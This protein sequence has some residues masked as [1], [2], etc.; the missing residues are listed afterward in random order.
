[1]VFSPF[2]V[3]EKLLE[4]LE[5]DNVDVEGF[6]FF[7]FKWCEVIV[8]L[9]ATNSKYRFKDTFFFLSYF[10]TC[11]PCNSFPCTFEL[12]VYINSLGDSQTLG[13]LQLLE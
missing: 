10:Y 7:I 8:S 6:L 4:T 9:M 1:M 11:A 5:N 2:S 13:V 3:D 12:N